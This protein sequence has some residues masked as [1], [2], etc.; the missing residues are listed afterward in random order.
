[1][2]A[3]ER[4]TAEGRLSGADFVRATACFAVLFHH[5]AQRMSWSTD[6]GVIE[7]FRVFAQIGALGV[8]IF[9]VLSGFLLARPYWKALDTGAAMPSTGVY[10]LRRAARILPGYWLALTAT[11]ICSVLIFGS[12]LDGWLVL[13]Y[14]SGVLLVSAWHWTT[15]FPVEVNGPLWS[16]SFE[17]ASYVLLPL[18]LMPLFLFWR[19]V[20]SQWLGRGFWLV[21]IAL[22]LLAHW[23]FTEFVVVDLRHRGWDFGLEGGAKTWMPRFNVFGFFAMFAVGALAA[24]IQVR[25]ARHRSW[26]FDLA[27]LVGVALVLWAFWRHSELPGATSEGFGLLGVPYDFPVLQL[28]VAFLLLT[29]PSSLLVGRLLDNPVICYLARISFGIYVWHYLVLELVRHY[30]A[31]DMD[32]G[33]MADPVKFVVA[34]V[35]VTVITMVIAHLSFHLVE[36]PVL[37][38]ARGRERGGRAAATLSPAAS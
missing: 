29:A 33:T 2:N 16:I 17:V 31:P 32:Q 24:G 38:W 11:F 23:L 37:R 13:R 28:A 22:A 7:P 6:L 25:V 15:L 35:V 5:L 3:T 34:S 1:M 10:A 30:W 27:A 9:F 14:I 20:G 18:A 26:L 12:N 36:E 4:T 19:R 21:V 8:A